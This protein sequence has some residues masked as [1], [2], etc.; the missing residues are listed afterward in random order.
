MG[1]TVNGTSRDL[2]WDSSF[3]SWDSTGV[4]WDSSILTDWNAVVAVVAGVNEV[5]KKTLQRAFDDALGFVEFDVNDLDYT[6]VYNEYPAIGDF[7]R[8]LIGENQQVSVG[9]SQDMSRNISKPIIEA[10]GTLV[11][12]ARSVQSFRSFS[13]N[14]GFKESFAK[15]LIKRKTDNLKFNDIYNNTFDKGVNEVF[16]VNVD[17]DDP[18]TFGREFATGVLINEDVRK[19]YMKYEEAFFGVNEFFDKE[20]LKGI[21]EAVNMVESEADPSDYRRYST[22]NVA[23]ATVVSKVLNKAVSS[24]LELR[25][26]FVRPHVVG[27]VSDIGLRNIA[28]APEE[29]ETQ[30]ANEKPHGFT[31]WE[32][33]QDGD[34][35]YKEALFK[36]WVKNLSPKDVADVKLTNHRIVCDVQDVFDKGTTGVGSSGSRIYFN[37]LFHNIPVVSVTSFNTSEFAIP[38]IT[39]IQ[40]EYFDVRLK[41]MD[42]TNAVGS[43]TWNAQGY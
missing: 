42:G 19:H 12:F 1:V 29:P 39:N 20:F 26:F 27:V 34:Y 36:L 40:R 38:E 37:R 5:R 3:A 2:T 21:L 17:R 15:E 25:D 22:V 41:K 28:I 13:E 32:V 14:V 18:T 9:V 33:F 23:I 30:T 24:G 8:K 11:N 16:G 6:K 4:T 35:Y 10:I 7:V 31:N 43:I